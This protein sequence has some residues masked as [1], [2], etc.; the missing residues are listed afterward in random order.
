MVV[1]WLVV[2]WSVGWWLVGGCELVLSFVGQLLLLVCYSAVLCRL[3][4]HGLAGRLFGWPFWR[5]AVLRCWLVGRMIG[6]LVGCFRLVAWWVGLL[7][8][9]LGGSLVGLVGSLL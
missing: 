9:C 1:G 3:V 7:C 6:W 5:W 2:G 8:G 4:A